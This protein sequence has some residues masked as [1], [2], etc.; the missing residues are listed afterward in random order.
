MNRLYRVQAKVYDVTR[1]LILPGRDLALSVLQDAPPGSS[2]LELGCGTARNLIRAARRYPHV[3]LFGSDLSEVM[4]AVARRNARGLP[5][6]LAECAAEDT[7]FERTFGR[8]SGFDVVLLSYMLTMQP[9]PQAAEAIVENA[10]QN[11]VPGGRLAIVDY[12]GYAPFPAWLRD[13]MLAWHASF[14]VTPTLRHLRQLEGWEREGR[15][16]LRTRILL[17]DVARLA[18]FRR[19]ALR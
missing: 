6:R 17:E 18:V 19:A 2:L 4:L 13:P 10:Y 9:S 5:I 3:E 12:S 14:S 1:W 7:H 11:L 15:G 8:S 16:V